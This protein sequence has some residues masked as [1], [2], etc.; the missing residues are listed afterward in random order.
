MLGAQLGSSLGLDPVS[1]ATALVSP[2]GP[3]R[4][5]GHQAVGPSSLSMAC[6]GNAEGGSLVGVG[7]SKRC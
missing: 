1:P 2:D 6:E 3:L 7:L 5:T 4:I